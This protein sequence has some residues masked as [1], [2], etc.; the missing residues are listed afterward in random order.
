MPSQP[1]V[2]AL[3]LAGGEGK[4]LYPL[5]R[6]RS[7]PAVPFG[8]Q[9]RLIDFVLSNIVNG[10]VHPVTG[11][12]SVRSYMHFRI[13]D[14]TAGDVVGNVFEDVNYGGGIG[15]DYATAAAD[16]EVQDFTGSGLQDQRR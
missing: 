13:Y 12:C 11:D 16:G 5:T 10:G 7:K 3:V 4:R 15:R 2:I 6:D 14:G 1:H 9:Y 8:G